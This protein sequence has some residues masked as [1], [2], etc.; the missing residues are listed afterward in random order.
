VPF[1]RRTV[2]VQAWPTTQEEGYGRSAKPITAVPLAE[3]FR[4]TLRPVAEL[5]GI[6]LKHLPQRLQG[7]VQAAVFVVPTKLKAPR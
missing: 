4:D 7:A 1:S 3:Q 5:R 2:H 6:D